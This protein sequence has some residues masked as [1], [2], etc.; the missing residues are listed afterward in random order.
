MT[1]IYLV[2]TTAVLAIASTELLRLLLHRVA[3]VGES[4]TV[5]QEW[6]PRCD[7]EQRRLASVRECAECGCAYCGDRGGLLMEA[8]LSAF[9]R[10]VRG[11]FQRSFDLAQY[12]GADVE[13]C[14]SKGTV[15]FSTRSGEF[16]TIAYWGGGHEVDDVVDPDVELDA[17]DGD[18]GLREGS[19]ASDSAVLAGHG[20][21]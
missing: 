11:T 4:I 7:R 13:L 10:G 5:G 18:L 15:M 20:A 14:P 3:D 21:L 19:H 8:A 2:V 1:T 9:D 17:R 12:L 16:E 6:N